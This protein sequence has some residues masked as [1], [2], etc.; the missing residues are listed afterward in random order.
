ME[1]NPHLNGSRRYHAKRVHGSRIIGHK[2]LLDRIPSMTR[3]VLSG[4]HALFPVQVTRSFLN[5]AEREELSDPLLPQVLPHAQELVRE[6]G[7]IDDPVGDRAKSPVPWVVQKHDD[8]VL[9]LLTKR[10]HLYCRYCFRR[11]HNPGEGM[12]PTPEELEGALVFCEQQPAREVILSGGDPLCLRTSELLKII[13][14]LQAS[15]K[16]VRIHT[17]GPISAPGQVRQDLVEGL[18]ARRPIW[19]VVHANHAR[20]IN[21]EVAA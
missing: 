18:A 11:D 21:E 20:E 9:L 5:R 3:E 12:D 13:D 7:D 14:R 17:R 10:C 6:S 1:Q 19:F 16:R 15:G 4:A 8:R 2:E